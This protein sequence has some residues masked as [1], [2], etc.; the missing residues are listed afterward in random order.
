M[1]PFQKLR[2]SL[3]THPANTI[4]PP[5]SHPFRE[6]ACS[7][8][9]VPAENKDTVNFERKKNEARSRI[10]AICLATTRRERNLFVRE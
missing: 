9:V 5:N 6:S 10:T 7:D 1:N 4:L 3:Y 8:L 2:L